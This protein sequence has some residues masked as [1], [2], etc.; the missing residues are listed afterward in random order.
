MYAPTTPNRTQ[1]LQILAISVVT[2]MC[3]FAWEG[4]KG[5]NLWDEGFYWYGVQ[6]VMHGE[7]PLRDFQ[8]Y[9]P[10]RYYWSAALMGLWGNAT[11][12][13]KSVV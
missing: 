9:D 6:R 12:D 8:A 5:L 4:T 13:R 3:L 10:F 7:V 1:Q 11:G 2:A